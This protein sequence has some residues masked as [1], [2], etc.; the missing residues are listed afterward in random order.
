MLGVVGFHITF[1]MFMVFYFTGFSYGRV[2]WLIIGATTTVVFFWRVNVFEEEIALQS[3]SIKQENELGRNKLVLIPEERKEFTEGAVIFKWL[4]VSLLAM[5]I[6]IWCVAG[7]LSPTGIIDIFCKVLVCLFLL[8]SAV[9]FF[10]AN[11]RKKNSLQKTDEE[12]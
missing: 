8:L 4:S 3:R 10:I 7:L 9:S 6:I 11:L 1:F 5:A 2:G 12:N